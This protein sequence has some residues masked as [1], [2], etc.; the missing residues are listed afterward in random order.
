MDAPR[1]A[2]AASLAPWLSVRDSVR[3]GALV[4]GSSRGRTRVLSRRR[5]SRI[6]ARLALGD[7][8]LWV[9]EESPEHQNFSPETVG[10]GSVRLI[11]TVDD[12]DALFARVLATG[13]TEIQ[14]VSEGHGWRVGLRA[15]SAGV[16]SGYGAAALRTR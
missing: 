4:R 2:L 9:A 11:L 12:A 3:G 7:A 1:P 15:R 5:P 13:A 14:P 8:E 16:A 10:R 6:V